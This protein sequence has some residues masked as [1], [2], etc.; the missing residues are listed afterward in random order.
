MA[1][2]YMTDKEFVSLYAKR[3]GIT[4]DEALEQIE[5]FTDCFRDC[6][7]MNNALNIR[8]LGVFTIGSR[9]N[10]VV[11]NPHTGVSAK[12]PL[13]YVIKYRASNGFRKL[14]NRKVKKDMKEFRK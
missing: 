6:I 5:T 4:V 2:K 12:M 14:L 8:N 10:T 11:R 7:V 13:M 9:R 1:T 3:L